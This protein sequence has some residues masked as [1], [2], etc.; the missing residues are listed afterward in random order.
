MIWG[1]Q[2]VTQHERKGQINSEKKFQIRMKNGTRKWVVEVMSSHLVFFLYK[3]G[4]YCASHHIGNSFLASSWPV[5]FWPS[6]Q[7]FPPSSPGFQRC[8]SS[9]LRLPSRL[10]PLNLDGLTILIT[11]PC[12]VNF[13]HMLNPPIC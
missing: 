9:L 6:M 4:H 5:R 10:A 11:D 12:H 7:A 1:G 3:M 8:I 13:D 2:K